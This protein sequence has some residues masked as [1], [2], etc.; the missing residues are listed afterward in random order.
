M[1]AAEIRA[2]ELAVPG[3]FRRPPAQR[4]RRAAAAA[5]LLAVLGL[6]AWRL[7]LNPVRILLG[8]RQLGWMM[9]MLL[10]P[11]HGGW[12]ADFVQGLGETLAM[13]FLGTLF[14]A[15]LA[16]PLG[17]LAARNVAAPAVLRA[18]LRRLFD[19]IRG[20]NSMVW[21]LM[22]VHVSGMGPFAGIMAITITDMATLAK[23]YA[24]TIENAD[25]RPIEGALSTGANRLQ[26]IRYALLPQVLPVILGNALYFYESNVR[27]ASVLGVLGAGGIGMRLYD[28]V[29]IM[30]WH[31]ASFIILM[32]L[33]TVGIMDALSKAARERI[34]AAPEV[35]P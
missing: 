15:L 20:I 19:V 34:V 22:F 12:L 18:G 30:D 33:A 31:Q 17:F 27:S 16:V 21:A 10:P 11:D 5:G 1:S 2:Y 3:A 14:G 32:I 8:L 13:A 24:E 28:R 7:D 26:V 25:P 4:L 9:P 35:R 6:A 23:L 29:R